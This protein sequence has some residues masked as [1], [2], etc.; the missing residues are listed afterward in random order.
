MNETNEESIATLIVVK[1]L[2]IDWIK[3]DLPPS[4]TYQEM[5]RDIFFTSCRKLGQ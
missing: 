4:N 1:P 2:L 3:L 5:F